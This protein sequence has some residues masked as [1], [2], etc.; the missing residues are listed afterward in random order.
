MKNRFNDPTSGAALGAFDR[1][2]KKMY[3]TA[4]RV[5]SLRRSGQMS[6]EEERRIRSQFKGTL[7][8]LF[9]EETAAW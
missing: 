5:R 3:K 6:W 4:E 1:E 8:K 7:L 2:L 9:D